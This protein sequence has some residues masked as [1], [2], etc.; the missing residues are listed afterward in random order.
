M[1]FSVT[2]ETMAQVPS[3]DPALVTVTRKITGATIEQALN[4]FENTCSE[5]NF[6][7]LTI[8]EQVKRSDGVLVRYGVRWKYSVFED[9]P[10]GF[11]TSWAL[12]IPEG[13]GFRVAAATREHIM[14]A[15][16]A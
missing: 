8:Q 5:E 13:A 6:Q 15:T 7:S 3:G 1:D 12:L 14:P 4:N 16:F 10:S 2:L 11:H 9:T